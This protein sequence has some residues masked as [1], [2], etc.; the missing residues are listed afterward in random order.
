[1]SEYKTFNILNLI[2]A[3]GEDGVNDILSGF[4]C[5]KNPEIESFVKK[6]AIDFAKRKISIT[7]LLINQNKELL[8]IYTLTHKALEIDPA[9]MSASS[10]RKISRFAKKNES[11]GKFVLSAFLIA[12]LGKNFSIPNDERL[13]GDAIMDEAISKLTAVSRDVGGGVVYLECEDEP[14]LLSFYSNQH[15]NYHTFNERVS[16]ADKVRYIQL[17]RFI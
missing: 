7:H 17:L 12:Q 13:S 5:P 8:A 10:V 9:G 16:A 11:D 2:D 4:S 15:N 1:M 6:N 14:K 3:I